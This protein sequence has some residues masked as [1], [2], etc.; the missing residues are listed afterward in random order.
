[1]NIEHTTETVV[2]HRITIV[3][4]GEDEINQFLVDPAPFQANVRK[5]RNQFLA[6]PNSWATNGRAN[7][8]LRRETVTEKN[9]AAFPRDPAGRGAVTTR[10]SA[11]PSTKYPAR[12]AA[13]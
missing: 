5:Q 13:N 4:E 11:R 7:G 2:K 6:R 9:R 8:H 3:L 10:A 12:T 1:M